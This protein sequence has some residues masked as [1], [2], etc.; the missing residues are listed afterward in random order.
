M[1]NLKIEIK[2]F[3]KRVIFELFLCPLCY[4]AVSIPDQHVRHSTIVVRCHGT[5]SASRDTGSTGTYLFLLNHHGDSG[6]C[7]LAAW[8]RVQ[9]CAASAQLMGEERATDVHFTFSLSY[10]MRR[11]RAQQWARLRFEQT[12]NRER[13]QMGSVWN[14]NSTSKL[15][16]GMCGH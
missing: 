12:C 1:P 13:A 5:C 6:L 2:V 3:I 11:A 4:H 15:V 8:L 9:L 16:Y 10:V 7:Y 14:A